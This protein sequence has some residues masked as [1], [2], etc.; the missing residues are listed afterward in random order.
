MYS[1]QPGDIPIKKFYGLMVSS[2]G[3]R[4]IALASTIDKEGNPNLSPFSCFN[5]FGSNPPIL[6]FSPMRRM[7]NSETKHTLHNVEATKEVVINVVN[8]D[9]VQQTS[10]ASTSYGDGVNEFEKTGLTMLDSDLI[11]PKRV[12]ESPV[13]YECKVSDIIY[14]GKEGGAAN[15]V[16]CEV[17]KMHINEAV[18]FADNKID[19]HKLD[20]VARMG[21]DWYTRAKDGMFKCPKPMMDHIGMGVDEL[22]E[23]IR[24][25]TVLTGN[26]LGKLGNTLAVPELETVEEFVK[27]KDLAAL[28]SR[29]PVEE[30]HR[31][32]QDY[33]KKNEVEEAWCIL[34]A[35][36]LKTT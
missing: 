13:H 21:G 18:M 23:T 5:F 9:I 36:T 16:I 29:K 10:L 17:V 6:V 20:Q 19:Q 7:A 14:T 3:P 26:D 15:L 11:K 8:Y 24:N 34:L 35:K 1:L 31:L 28:I 4:P 27:S 22:P 12:A 30:I 32:A 33:L 25:S 2:V